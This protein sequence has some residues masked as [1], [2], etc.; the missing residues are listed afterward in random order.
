M[1]YADLTAELQG[2]A[3]D[4]MLNGLQKDRFIESTLAKF[5]TELD[6]LDIP[7][8]QASIRWAQKSQA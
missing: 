7:A 2:A 3:R 8:I 4:D 5:F 6:Y 1:T